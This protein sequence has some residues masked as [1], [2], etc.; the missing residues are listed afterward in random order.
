MTHTPVQRRHA[1]RR[2]RHPRAH[3]PRQRPRPHPAQH[4]RT[5]EHRGAAG[6]RRRRCAPAPR[7]ARSR[8]SASPASRSSSPSA[9]TCR[10]VAVRRPSA[11]RPS[12]SPAPATRHSPPIMDLP[13]PTFAFVN[14]AAMGGGVEIALACDHRTISAGR[15]GVRAARDLP[16]AR[17][18][19]G[20]L[21]PA[22]EPHRRRRTPSRSSSRTRCRRTGCSRAKEVAALGI[23]DVLL[24]PADFLEDSLRWAAGVALR[25]G[26]RASAR[27]VDRD[28]AAWDGRVRRRQKVVLAKTGGR[29]PGALRARRARARPPAPPTRDEAFA[30]EDEALGRPRHGRRA[31][32][33]ALRLRPRAAAGQAPRR[34][35]RQ[36]AGPTGHQGRHRR[37]RPDG[38]PARAA[39]RPAPRG[40]GRA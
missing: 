36:G 33:R 12:R 15:P 14:G 4:L 27:E 37:R 29:A 6:H 25:R 10:G 24:E 2:R 39:L 28:E 23:A 1:P 32:G 20:R 5:A 3:H 17:A 11:S 34:R 16:R 26:H 22:A 9:P 35:A 13:V 18:R 19:L 38:Q 30:A 40:A 7:P 31:A 8:P 21:L